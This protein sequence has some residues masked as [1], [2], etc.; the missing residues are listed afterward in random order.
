MNGLGTQLGRLY[1][2]RQGVEAKISQIDEEIC[3]VE[4]QIDSLVLPTHAGTTPSAR[5]PITAAVTRP[6]A[7]APKAPVKV[8]VKKA[9]KKAAPKVTARKATSNG[10]APRPNSQSIRK[11]AEIAEQGGTVTIEKYAETQEIDVKTA[12]RRLTRYEDAGLL[13]RE[14]NTFTVVPAT[15]PSADAAPV[16]APAPA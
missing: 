9:K 14:G 2:E 11:I 1:E 6:K 15:K 12:T 13:T 4:A 7:A 16:A 8:A 3:R 5:L 10:S